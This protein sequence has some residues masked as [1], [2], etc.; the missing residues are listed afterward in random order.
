MEQFSDLSD[1]ALFSCLNY[2]LLGIRSSAQQ[3][4]ETYRRARREFLLKHHP[5]KGAQD[6]DKVKRANT[7]WAEY[8]KRYK[9]GSPQSSPASAASTPQDFSGEWPQALLPMFVN[10]L[11]GTQASCYFVLAPY[12]DLVPLRREV[13]KLKLEDLFFGKRPNA[14]GILG[15]M[16]SYR[17][18]YKTLCKKVDNI[19]KRG[20]KVGVVRPKRYRDAKRVCFGDF[21]DV[22][23][24][25][26]DE[27][28]QEPLFD[29]TMLR[30]F[31]MAL[32]ITDPVYLHGLYG[33]EM[34]LPLADCM[35]C[36]EDGKNREEFQT[37]RPFHLKH[38]ENSLCFGSVREQRKACVH[39]CDSVHAWLRLRMKTQT[40]E[41]FY[42]E[43]LEEVLRRVARGNIPATAITAQ[44]VLWAH[45]CPGVFR[46]FMEHVYSA[47]VVAEPKRRGLIFQGPFDCGKTTIAQ[48]I[49][50][51]FMGCSLNV[52]LCKERLGF[53]L[54]GAIDMRMV[55]FDDVTG[56]PDSARG[57]EGGWGFRNLD[58]LRDHLDGCVPV[59]LERKHQQRIEQVFPPW[60]LTCNEY[61]IPSAVLVRGHR[62][63]FNK[64]LGD[65]D[66]FMRRWDIKRSQ[67]VSASSYAIAMALYLP[68]SYFPESCRPL[69]SMIKEDARP[70]IG[71]IELS[72]LDLECHEE[73]LPPSPME[74]SQPSQLPPP[75]QQEHSTQSQPTQ[76]FD[77]SPRVVYFSGTRPSDDPGEG[78]SEKRPR[79]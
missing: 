48:S 40:A 44:G 55:L 22:F 63:Q 41:Q 71:P 5:D 17:M 10:A 67:L 69:V 51:F 4:Y 6:E 32:K 72:L 79:H 8:E 77:F 56:A 18:A 1:A 15:F 14:T 57:L 31:A 7:L 19:C 50:A 42:V 59:G 25:L 9:E 73:M 34:S 64:S 3:T 61:Y 54:G 58:S 62:I 36:V 21:T 27:E 49:R 75:P 33:H 26:E 66:E 29:H 65:P 24:T 16:V 12:V 23:G 70:L 68:G 28:D 11:P 60:I 47:L 52:N 13:E 46:D 38:H 45:M 74:Q 53:E 76:Q 43:R 35:L 30:E 78:P 37:H 39:A 2:L 20:S